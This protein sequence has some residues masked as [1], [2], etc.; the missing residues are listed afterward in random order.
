MGARSVFVIALCLS[1]ASL[2]AGAASGEWEFSAAC[3]SPSSPDHER[4]TTFYVSFIW[5][6]GT[7]NQTENGTGNQTGGG[8]GNQTG[9]QNATGNNNT[10]A[11]GPNITVNITGVQ[12]VLGVNSGHPRTVEQRFE[13]ERAPGTNNYTTRQGPWAPGVELAY[14]FEAFL[15]NGAV[16]RSNES[17]TRTPDITEFIWHDSYDEAAGLA[18]SLGRPLLVFVYSDLDHSS[19]Y[20]FSGPFQV[21]EAIALSAGF[22]CLRVSADADPALARQLNASSTPCLVFMN[23]STGRTLDRIP[24]GFDGETLVKE[25]RYILH[26]GPRPTRPGPFIA[27]TVIG[28]MI[29]GLVL[30]AGSASMYH[31]YVKK[32]RER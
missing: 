12:V 1:I 18:V 7:G 21:G 8:E 26:K 3:S 30:V 17:R 28:L 16:I 14:H 20:M 5:R 27:D 15:S 2:L 9:E 24:T 6:D 32:R 25:M 11:T 23:A 13:L 22:V 29:L 4:A 19:D 31:Y 10:N